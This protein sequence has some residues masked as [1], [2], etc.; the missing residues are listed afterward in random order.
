MGI[1]YDYAN[2][3]YE[4]YLRQIAEPDKQPTQD[5]IILYCG[6]FSCSQSAA[7]THQPI[8]AINT[9]EPVRCRPVTSAM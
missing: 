1:G 6:G 7:F 4:G 5:R 3:K 9:N 2:V 8:N